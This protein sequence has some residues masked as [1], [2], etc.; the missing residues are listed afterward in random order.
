MMRKVVFPFFFISLS[1]LFCGPAFALTD[2]VLCKIPYEPGSA[3][4]PTPRPRLVLVEG[5]SK[6][7]P[8]VSFYGHQTMALT[9]ETDKET[10]VI[11][12]DAQSS[13]YFFKLDS[14]RGRLVV[15]IKTPQND[16]G[17]TPGENEGVAGN[18]SPL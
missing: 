11:S 5:M 16:T 17:R 10:G 12:L 2:S 7:Q 13:R 3:E 14:V 15:S 4:G 9:K 6:G 18:C 1:S 8:L